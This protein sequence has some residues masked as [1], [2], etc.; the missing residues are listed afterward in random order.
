MSDVL[1]ICILSSVRDSNLEVNVR[2]KDTVFFPPVDLMYKITTILMWSTWVYRVVH[3]TCLKHGK[4]IKTQNIG[5]TSI[6]L[7]RRDWSSIRLDRMQSSFKKHFQLVVFRKFLGWKLEK[8]E[9]NKCTCFIGF[10]QRS[11]WNTSGKENWVQNTL[12]EQRL[13]NYLQVSKRTNQ[14]KNQIVRE[15][16]D[17]LSGETRELSKMEEK[18]PVLRRSMLILCTKNLFSSENGETRFWNECN[19]STFIW[20]Q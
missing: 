5:L 19:P 1:S 18:R 3:S 7:L 12:N 6:L 17:P 10:H 9:T 8:S 2:A 11:F 16:W 13:G 20:R 14:F 4:D 15:R